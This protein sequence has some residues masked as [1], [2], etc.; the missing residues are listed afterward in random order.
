VYVRD[1][2]G[3]LRLHALA[4]PSLEQVTDVVRW[5]HEQLVRVCERHSRSLDEFDDADDELA[6]DQPALA[7]CYGVSVHDQQLLGA[8][9]AN[10]PARQPGG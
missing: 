4:N 9:P 8:A 1:A 2:A 3:M 6:H 5:T 10:A 7:A